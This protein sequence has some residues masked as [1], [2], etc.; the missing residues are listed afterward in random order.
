MQLSELKIGEKARIISYRQGEQTYRQRLLA[1]GLL[2]GTMIT[3][4]RIAPLGDPI[5]ILARGIALSLRKIEATLLQL[6]TYE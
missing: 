1:M 6:E 5:E 3:L 2:P 4:S